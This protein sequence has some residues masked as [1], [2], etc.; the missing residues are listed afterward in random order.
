MMRGNTCVL[1]P[2]SALAGKKAQDLAHT[3][4]CND[5]FCLNGGT[6]LFD[7]DTMSC[8]CPSRFNGNRCQEMILS[9]YS[10]TD[11]NVLAWVF[12]ILGICALLLI[13]S[14]LLSTLQKKHPIE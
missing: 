3:T 12:G 9:E 2:D 5:G 7:G 11:V 14:I 1:D 10:Q 6:C 8:E 4:R 13:F